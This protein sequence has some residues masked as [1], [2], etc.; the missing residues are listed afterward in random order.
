MTDPDPMSL[1]HPKGARMSAP[2]DEVI[3]YPVVVDEGLDV[4]SIYGELQERGLVKVRLPFGEPCWLATRYDDVRA[5]YADRRFSRAAGFEHDVP[6]VW[7]GNS[8]IDPSMPLAMDPPR[9]TRLR[10]LTSK[11]FSPKRIRELHPWMEQEVDAL[12]DSFAD[13][14]PTADFV[15]LFAWNLPIRVLTGV[16]GV[17]RDDA[18]LFRDW[19]EISTAVTTPQELRVETSA[20]LNEYV[21]GLIAD[22]RQTPQK[23]LL[24]DLVHA[25]DADDRLTEAELLGLVM[26]LMAGGFETTAWQLG[27]TVYTLMVHPDHWREIVAEPGIRPRAL[28]E[29]WRWVPSMKYG[30]NFVR[31]AT[32]EVELSGGA[33]VSPGDAVLPEQAV[34]NR[35]ESVFAHGSDLDFHRPDPRPHLSLG[36]GEHFC[37]GAH[38]AQAQ[39][40]LTVE[41]LARRFP[42]LELAVP[43]EDVRWAAGSFM[44]S[45]ENLPLAW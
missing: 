12:F 11:A 6:R 45:V 31:W 29:I 7:P 41:K 36:F 16:V 3:D 43:Q 32:A 44:R 10:R 26:S 5:V 27:T 28:E 33:V 37:M 25:R 18:G 38:L 24:S 39:I 1:T 2:A 13:H 35:D 40:G 9:H 30:T 8:L 22:R 23:D 19:V 42:Q 15:A 34:A 20:K 17:P 4:S 21:A 14:G